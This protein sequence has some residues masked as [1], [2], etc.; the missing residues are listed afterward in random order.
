MTEEKRMTI[1]G[2]PCPYCGSKYQRCFYWCYTLGAVSEVMWTDRKWFLDHPGTVEYYR[3]LM[4]P[5]IGCKTFDGVVFLDDRVPKMKVTKLDEYVR[6]RHYPLDKMA[7]IIA[8][9]WMGEDECKAANRFFQVTGL[10]GNPGTFVF[11]NP[12]KDAPVSGPPECESPPEKLFWDAINDVGDTTLAHVTPQWKVK[13]YRLDFA[14]PPKKLAIEVDGLAFHNGQAS[15]IKDRNRQRD[16][17]MEGWRVLR[18]AAKEIMDD[19]K[20]CVRQAASWAAT[21]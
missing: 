18:F 21:A 2:T 9:P 17:E 10:I 16:L 12:P 7:V 6:S 3:E 15:F 1:E 4:P 19:A 20:G 11:P 5:D 14:I 8:G 13:N